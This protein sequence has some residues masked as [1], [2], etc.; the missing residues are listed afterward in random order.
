MMQPIARAFTDRFRPVLVE[1]HGHGRSSRP[2]DPEMYSMREFADDL[3][4]IADALGQDRIAVFGTSLGADVA[5]ETMM[6]HPDRIAGAILEMPVLEHGAK[7]A[8]RMFKPIA[9]ALRSKYASRTLSA[10]SRRLPHAKF[11]PGFPEALEH[12]AREPAVGAA[13]IEGL[14]E[15]AERHRWDDV[16]RCEVPALVI[17]HAMDPLHA[18]ADAREVAAKLPHA[19]LVRAYSILELRVRPKRLVG[20]AER[21]LEEVFE[22]TRV[23]LSNEAG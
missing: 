11:M 10:V 8:R 20:L 7:A 9:K 5:L 22:P 6:D 16:V 12:L 14:L 1:L 21:F 3:V 4:A 15:E 13:V 18:F 2:T 17:A 23:K 19:E